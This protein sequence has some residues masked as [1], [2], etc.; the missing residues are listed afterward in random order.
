V[1]IDVFG[2]LAA[3]TVKHELITWIKRLQS[4]DHLEIFRLHDNPLADYDKITRLSVEELL[5]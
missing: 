3:F 5:K 4:T 2:P 1:V